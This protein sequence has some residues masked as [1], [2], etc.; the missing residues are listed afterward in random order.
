[1]VRDKIINP[2]S[3][4]KVILEKLHIAHQSVHR[5]KAKARKVLCWPG[6]THDIDMQVEKCVQYQQ[7]QPR[8]QKEPLFTHEVPELPRMKYP[9]VLNSPDL[10][11]QIVIQKMKSIFARN[12]IPKELGPHL[13]K[14]E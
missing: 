2:Q 8:Q 13:S 10:T 7:F 14:R 3:F 11:A 6:I 5:T 4:R 12:G 9:E 1:M